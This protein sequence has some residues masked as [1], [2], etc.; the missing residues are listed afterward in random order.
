MSLFPVGHASHGDWRVAADA[1][2]Q[3]L[4]GQMAAPGHAQRP[5]LGLVYFAHEHARHAA[6]LLRHLAR[7]LP[8]VAD[9]A[10]CSAGGVLAM[11]HE[12]LSGPALAV[13]LLDVPAA[14]YRLYSGLAPL[15]A[16]GGE[17]G[18]AAD[19]AL[20]HAEGGQ[21][22][23][24]ELLHELSDRTDSGLLFGGLGSAGEEGVDGVQIACRAEDLA[25]LHAG[26]ASGIFRGGFSGVAFSAGLGCATGMAQGC[27]PLGAGLQITEARGALVTGLD[28]DPALQRLLQLLGVE[29][30]GGDWQPALSTVR[31]TLAAIAPPGRGVA[32]GV[33]T[34]EAQVLTLVGLDPLRQGV[35]LSAAV[36]AGHSVIFCRRQAQAARQELM[37][38][39]AALRDAAEAGPDMPTAQQD[40][41]RIRGALYISCRGRGGGLFGGP[42]AELRTLRHALGDVPL[43]GFVAEAQIMDAR[44]HRFAGVL[45]VF[46]A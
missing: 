20:V 29:L 3:Q 7:G 23:L 15:Q 43:I 8:H 19:S 26:S 4:R 46:T 28:G 13:M 32:H 35:A 18:F 36:E 31:T 22:E 1:V 42:D 45:T 5:R 10:G 39:G 12:Y 14:H 27:A 40:R 25:A 24:A 16:T 34:E 38:L 30:D 44:L 33:L 2:L 6:P 11:G 17:A 21:P 9:W 41:S 37:Q